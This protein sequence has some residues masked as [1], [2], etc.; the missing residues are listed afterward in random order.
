MPI[1]DRYVVYHGSEDGAAT[2]GL[3]DTDHDR[4]YDR[5]RA[6]GQVA[7]APE[8]LPAE[9]DIGDHFWVDI[10]DTQQ[11]RGI[12]AVRF[13]P[14]LTERKAVEYQVAEE[15]YGEMQEWGRKRLREDETV[16]NTVETS[17]GTWAF[18]TLDVG[19]AN[20]RVLASQNTT[21]LIDAAEDRIVTSL[22]PVMAE[23]ETDDETD[24]G[25]IDYFVAT[26]LHPDHVAGIQSLYDEGYTIQ[27]A[28]LPNTARCELGIEGGVMKDVFNEYIAALSAH[29]IAPRD[30]EQVATGDVIFREGK[31]SL[32]VLA[33][34]ATE[35]VIEFD[36]PTSGD[37]CVFH[38]GN[39]NANGMVCMFETPLTS[40]LFMGD[41]RDKDGTRAESW[42]VAMHHDEE[43]DIDLAADVLC[44][45]LHGSEHATR[46]PFLDVVKPEQVFFSA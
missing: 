36:H 5:P 28:Y 31:A 4:G 39:A 37:A 33:P 14:D 23:L 35:R 24:R 27:R 6:M 3:Y 1:N 8:A 46:P 18:S 10:D 20:A 29:G 2:F 38:P 17:N 30:I 22:D 41:V 13:G 15:T 25:T 44:P 11:S 45:G 19:H 32:G 21:V 7:V 34:P 12:N 9:F 42:L 40:I 16:S 26:H 43:S